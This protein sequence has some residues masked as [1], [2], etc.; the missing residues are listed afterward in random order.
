MPRSLHAELVALAEAE[1]VSLNQ[2]AVSS[3]ARTA[4]RAAEG[5]AQPA[6]EA[7]SPYEAID[8]LDQLEQALHLLR[9][10]F[11]DVTQQE[12][13]ELVKVVQ[14]LEDELAEDRSGVG[15]FLTGVSK[16]LSAGIDGSPS[17]AEDF[18]R[19][20]RIKSRSRAR[21]RSRKA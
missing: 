14:E 15:Q 6:R 2:L 21:R 3:L 12:L 11:E 1:G 13:P 17:L 16:S 9:D 7:V 10:R 19:Q 5:E 4:A 20:D 8:R 18:A